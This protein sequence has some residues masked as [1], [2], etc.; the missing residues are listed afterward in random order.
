MRVTPERGGKKK[1]KKQCA[2]LGLLLRVSLWERGGMFT[3]GIVDEGDKVSGGR[4]Q[5]IQA[6]RKIRSFAHHTIQGGLP[7][8]EGSVS[9]NSAL[10]KQ[11]IGPRWR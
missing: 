8:L 2:C 4:M 9:Q 3:A 7:K 6:G 11:D 5:P 10:F 1:K